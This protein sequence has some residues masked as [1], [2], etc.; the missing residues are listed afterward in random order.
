MGQDP[1]GLVV[2][3]EAAIRRHLG[4]ERLLAGMAERGVAE[5]VGQRQG[6]G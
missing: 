6:F 4:V 2:V 5:V 3:R 1:Q